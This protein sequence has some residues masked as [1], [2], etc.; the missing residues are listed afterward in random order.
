MANVPKSQVSTLFQGAANAKGR[1]TQENLAQMIFSP[2]T[3]EPWAR[4]KKRSK[5]EAVRHSVRPPYPTWGPNSPR[6]RSAF[7]PRSHTQKAGRALDGR[8]QA[9]LSLR[10]SFVFAM[11]SDTATI[12]SY[13]ARVQLG[14]IPVQCPRGPARS[15]SAVRSPGPA[16]KRWGERKW[17]AAPPHRAPLSVWLSGWPAFPPLTHPAPCTDPAGRDGKIMPKI[18]EPLPLCR[19][20]HLAK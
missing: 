10:P 7:S 19:L 13:R 3:Q 5:A 2:R 9:N 16:P 12:D 14:H 15:A 6:P 20:Y 18:P 11:H 4:Q 17:R 1:L 8:Q